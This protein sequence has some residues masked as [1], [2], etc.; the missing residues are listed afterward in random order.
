L[1]PRHGKLVLRGPLLGRIALELSRRPTTPCAST[2]YQ[3]VVAA[4][5]W[6]LV[7]DGAPGFHDPVAL[8]LP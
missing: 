4:G 7:E 6:V 3:G 5:I 2:Q 1:P 8:H